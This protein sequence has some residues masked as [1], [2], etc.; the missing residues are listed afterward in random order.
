ME[1]YEV[2]TYVSLI[3]TWKIRAPDAEV[4]EGLALMKS[5]SWADRLRVQSAESTDVDSVEI[6][7]PA[8][9]LAEIKRTQELIRAVRKGVPV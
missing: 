2:T 6:W 1:T 4:A 9:T 8:E 3:R 5:K 7:E